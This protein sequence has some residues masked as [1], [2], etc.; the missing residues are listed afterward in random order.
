MLVG[1][2]LRFPTGTKWEYSNSNYALLPVVVERASGQKFADFMRAE[3]TRWG[4]LIRKLGIK[5][6]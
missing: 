2:K 4:A 1:K 3:N 6:D 5:L